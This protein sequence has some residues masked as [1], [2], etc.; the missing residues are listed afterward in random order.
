[1]AEVGW[2]GDLTLN[3]NAEATYYGAAASNHLELFEPYFQTILDYLPA[4]RI[5]A[6][7][8]YPQCPGALYFAGH[9]LPFGVTTSSN[10]DMGQKQM[11]LFASVPFILFW[12]YERD[13]SFAKRQR[14]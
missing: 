5:L 1:M 9:I 7:V 11:G 12:R 14:S 6:A 13:P 8:Q 3:Y 2:M 10:G 4:A